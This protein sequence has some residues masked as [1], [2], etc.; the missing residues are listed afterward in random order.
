MFELLEIY[1]EEN[2]HSNVPRSYKTTP[3]SK[4][5]VED[6]GEEVNTTTTT[7]TSTTK[8]L[9]TWL[10]TQRQAKTKGILDPIKEQKLNRIGIV[11]GGN[12]SSQ[13]WNDMLTLLKEYKGQYGDC[14][15]PRHYNN[16]N[17]NNNNR[18]L[19]RWLDRQRQLKK[20]DKLS[21]KKQ[22][23]LEDIGVVF[24]HN[25]TTS[26]GTGSS[27]LDSDNDNNNDNDNDNDTNN[28]VTVWTQKWEE[29]FNYLIWYQIKEGH[30]NVPK[31]YTIT[32]T[33]TDN[34]NATQTKTINLGIWLDTQRRY[35][36]IQK[37]DSKRQLRLEE[38]GI[39]WDLHYKTWNY[40]FTLLNEYK[41][42]AGH[43][44]VPKHYKVEEEV[45]VEANVILTTTEDNNKNND[46]EIIVHNLGYWLEYQRARKRRGLV[47]MKRV[48]KLESIG[49]VWDPIVTNCNSNWDDMYMLLKE[50]KNEHGQ[51]YNVPQSFKVQ[52]KNDHDNTT[53]TKHLGT[54]LYTQR[55]DKKKGKL[56][57]E[58][59]NRLEEIGVVWDVLL[60]KWE[61]MF[62]LLVQYNEREGNCIM[63]QDRKEDGENLGAWLTTQRMDK[64]KGKLHA[65]KE[66][67]LNSIGNFVWDLQSHKW[68]C[69]F[70]L[71][72]QYKNR[73]GDCNVPPYYIGET[74]NDH[75]NNLGLWLNRQRQN[76]KNNKLDIKQQHSLEEI[77]VVWDVQSQK[78][79]SMFTLLKEYSQ[80][81]GTCSIRKSYKTKNGK[82]LGIW[83]QTQHQKKLDGTLDIVLQHR[84]ENIGFI[85]RENNDN[86]DNKYD[87][88]EDDDRIP[89]NAFEGMDD[90][91]G[92]SW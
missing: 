18:L 67:K 11:W 76:K 48:Q 32:T 30:C 66:D 64:K 44:N 16:N 17:N 58:K 53:S 87:D 25:S 90:L 42:S 37:L 89:K 57:A 45:K 88:N 51:C 23:Q 68:E 60:L 19:G 54:W 81:E 24:N 49:I 92:D 13:K 41:Q 77:G 38:L 7:T 52:I 9:G 35:K 74:N 31:H 86:H 70:E 12:V 1:K 47:N 50:Y 62:T 3:S 20:N 85:W 83:V 61:H 75:K 22:N 82:S 84:L 59:Q 40:M 73:E 2:G 71:L 33:Y 63:P 46:N 8:N 55:M 72:V 79:E 56:D 29:M 91:F 10:N 69:M 36:K 28:I 4:N 34:G 5:D 78:W 6:D 43:C 21:M 14:Y 15:V 39:E 27:M 65:N 26:T 80:K